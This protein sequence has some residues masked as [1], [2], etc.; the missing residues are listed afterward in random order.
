MAR[1]DSGRLVLSTHDVS[2]ARSSTTLSFSILFSGQDQSIFYF[3][4]PVTSSSKH[5]NLDLGC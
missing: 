2:H 1:R 4:V 3:Y 5:E